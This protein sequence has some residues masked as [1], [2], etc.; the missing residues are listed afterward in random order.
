[1]SNSDIDYT[2]SLDNKR[3]ALLFKAYIQYT[4]Y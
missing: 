2:A 4:K 3:T 1:M